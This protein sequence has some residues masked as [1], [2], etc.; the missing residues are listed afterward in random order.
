VDL[1]EVF[2]QDAVDVE[3][4]D[5]SHLSLLT[6]FV[7]KLLKWLNLRVSQGNIWLKAVD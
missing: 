2:S 7:E 3:G 4:D 6:L 1:L 5:L